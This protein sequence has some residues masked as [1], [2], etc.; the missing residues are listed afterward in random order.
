MQ[1]SPDSELSDE[2]AQRSVQYAHTDERDGQT[3]LQTAARLPRPGCHARQ[4]PLALSGLHESWACP[5]CAMRSPDPSR[6]GSAAPSDCSNT[7]KST[8][9]ACSATPLLQQTGIC[10]LVPP[11]Q[12]HSEAHICSTQ[13]FAHGIRSHTVFAAMHCPTKASSRAATTAVGS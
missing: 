6:H 9:P 7:R 12:T 4:R 10:A 2:E 3:H 5:D 11:W 1:V 13:R 8:T